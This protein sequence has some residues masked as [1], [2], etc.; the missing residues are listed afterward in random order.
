VQ[1][2]ILIKQTPNGVTV[3]LIKRAALVGVKMPLS[4]KQTDPEN[5]Y[6]VNR[7]DAIAALREK[8]EELADW[9]ERY[10]KSVRVKLLTFP[11]K[12]CD[13]VEDDVEA[14]PPKR[15]AAAMTASNRRP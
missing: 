9:W 10:L 12:V 15:S 1:K 8:S 4:K 6:N 5:V 14:V 2:K 7:Q 3:P 13:L 11:H